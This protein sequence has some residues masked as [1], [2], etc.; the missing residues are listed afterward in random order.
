M[1]AKSEYCFLGQHCTDFGG[2]IDPLLGFSGL[3][4]LCRFSHFMLPGE[5]GKMSSVILFHGWLPGI[6]FVL[7]FLVL[8]GAARSVINVCFDC[9]S[10]LK[11]LG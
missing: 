2:K 11:T 4:L 8:L 9:G 6:T 5:H 1:S 10:R 7:F 3:L